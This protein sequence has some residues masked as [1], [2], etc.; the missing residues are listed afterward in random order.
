[1]ELNQFE[2]RIDFPWEEIPRLKPVAN[3]YI[4]KQGG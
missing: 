1:M 3:R 2:V 4:I